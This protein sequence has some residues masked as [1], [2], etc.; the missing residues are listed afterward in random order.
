MD[1][2]NGPSFAGYMVAISGLFIIAVVALCA[3]LLMALFPIPTVMSGAAIAGC[4]VLYSGV[5][6]VS[7]VLDPKDAKRPS[8]PP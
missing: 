6:F 8:D 3:L 4:G 7:R 5:R 2:K 1:A